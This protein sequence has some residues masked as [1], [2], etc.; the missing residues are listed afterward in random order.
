[1]QVH[2]Q[3]NNRIV[4]LER[5]CQLKGLWNTPP[6][7]RLSPHVVAANLSIPKGKRC[8]GICSQ[9]VQCTVESAFLV[10]SYLLTSSILIV[11]DL[12]PQLSIDYAQ[13]FF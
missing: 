9:L 3:H 1:M 8:F 12:H 6:C 13:L 7:R 5:F 10:Y 11:V 2:A 4:D